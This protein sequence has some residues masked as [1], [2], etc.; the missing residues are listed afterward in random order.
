[1]LIRRLND[2]ITCVWDN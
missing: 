2:L 1:M